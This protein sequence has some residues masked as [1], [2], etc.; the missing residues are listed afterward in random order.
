MRLLLPTKVPDTM[1]A[2]TTP[3]HSAAPLSHCAVG[4]Q[5]TVME[6][7]GTTPFS[8]RLREFGLLPGVRVRLLRSG[9][10]LVVQIGQTRLAIRRCDAEAIRI[11]S[12]STYGL[13]TAGTALVA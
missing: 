10:S 11:C 4:S 6:I 12:D 13:A 9:A 1:H 2:A 7:A 5:G 3:S 8:T